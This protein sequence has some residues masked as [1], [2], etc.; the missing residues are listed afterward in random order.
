MVPHQKKCK[1]R[2]F[3]SLTDMKQKTTILKKNAMAKHRGKLAL[4]PEQGTSHWKL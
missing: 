3:V 4:E 2:T 1:C